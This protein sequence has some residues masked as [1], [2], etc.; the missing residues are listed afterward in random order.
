MTHWNRLNGRCQTIVYN[1]DIG[2]SFIGRAA[3]QPPLLSPCNNIIFPCPTMGL[4]LRWE[5]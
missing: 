2:T 1:E 5:F 4:K 3:W